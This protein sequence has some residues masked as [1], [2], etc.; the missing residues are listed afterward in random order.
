MLR[1]VLTLL[2][3][4]LPACSD[5]APHQAAPALG[6][7]PWSNEAE[8]IFQNAEALKY[9]LEQH[10]LEQ[11]RLQE[12]DVEGKAPVLPFRGK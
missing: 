5:P 1:S 10:K 8:E 11:Q 7:D 12:S 3:L 2:P 4:L 9:A 6:G